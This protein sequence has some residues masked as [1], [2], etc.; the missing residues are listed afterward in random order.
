MYRV[1]APC[2]ISIQ[3]ILYRPPLWRSGLERSPR[4]RKFGCS[5]PSRDR[6][7]S[8]NRKVTAPLPNARNWVVVS[9]VLGDDHYERMLRVTVVVARYGTLTAHWP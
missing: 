2:L 5:N 3:L 4:K 6:P 1:H 7:K 8:L 9:R